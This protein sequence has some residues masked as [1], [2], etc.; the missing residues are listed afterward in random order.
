MVDK[1]QHKDGGETGRITDQH[2]DLKDDMTQAKRKRTQT[3]T[4]AAHSDVQRATCHK[5][6]Q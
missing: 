2:S 6:T 4:Q 5:R 3:K 1:G